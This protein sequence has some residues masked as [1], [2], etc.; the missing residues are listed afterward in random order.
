MNSIEFVQACE[1]GKIL[2]W[3]REGLRTL[4]RSAKKLYYLDLETGFA[5]TF[6][7]VEIGGEHNVFMMIKDNPVGIIPT[8]AW[9]LLKKEG[10]E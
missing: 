3:G 4:H 10:K 6:D 9:D 1:D 2:V 5:T 7:R 8:E